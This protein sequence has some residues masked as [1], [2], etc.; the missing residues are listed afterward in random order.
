MTL[1]GSAKRDPPAWPRV[2]T[3]RT[4]KD[5]HRIID[6]HPK[7]RRLIQSR[8]RRASGPWPP[9]PPQNFRHWFTQSAQAAGLPWLSRFHALRH[10]VGWRWLPAVLGHR[11]PKSTRIYSH[12]SREAVGRTIGGLEYRKAMEEE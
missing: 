10:T 5:H 7:L 12:L 2:K 9:V 11:D 4:A 8:P 6:I 1:E 3:R